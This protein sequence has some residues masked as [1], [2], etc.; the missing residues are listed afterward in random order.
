M[1]M[2]RNPEE[3]SVL[4]LMDLQIDF[5][6]DQGRLPVGAANAERVVSIANSMAALFEERR[7][8][9]VV[10]FNQFKESDVI[11][12]FF[13]RY[14]A[15][16]G[17]EGGNMDPRVLV[18]NA[19]CFS[20]AKSSAFTNPDF[21]GYLKTSGIGHVVICGVYAEGCVRATAFDSLRSNLDTVVL[22]DGVS[23]KRKSTY[24]WALSHMRKRGVRVMSFEEYLEPPAHASSI[25]RSS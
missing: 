13:R 17:S 4:L 5:L 14:A 11:G 8:P 1:M 2:R 9:I 18:H 7:W 19:R 3:M 22:S 10:I 23:S 21:G 16:E 25:S 15:L 12:N 20:K 24:L 6:S